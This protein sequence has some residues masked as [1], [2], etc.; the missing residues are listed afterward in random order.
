MDGFAVCAHLKGDALTRHIPV[1][2]VTG[3]AD[4]E[5]RI[6]GLHARANDFITKP[7]DVTE[8]L[9]KANNFLKLKEYDKL[10]IKHEFLKEASSVIAA[11]KKDWELIPNC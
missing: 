9:I 1:I 4:K 3:L 8:L 11:A 7:F 10:M 2:M 6:K 5:S